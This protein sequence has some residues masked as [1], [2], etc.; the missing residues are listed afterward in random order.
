MDHGEDEPV[1]EWAPEWEAGVRVSV[2]SVFL[3]DVVKRRLFSCQGG[4]AR[5]I[6]YALYGSGLEVVGAG[7]MWRL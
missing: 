1:W 4:A 7:D 5:C 6:P 2:L 3:D